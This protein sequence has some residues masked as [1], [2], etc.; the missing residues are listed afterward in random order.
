MVHF[1]VLSLETGTGSL[2]SKGCFEG[3]SIKPSVP[4]INLPSLLHPNEFAESWVPRCMVKCVD[5][6]NTPK[7]PKIKL[8]KIE[9]GVWGIFVAVN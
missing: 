6:Q 2:K 9:L 3:P 7:Y 1:P 5:P 4:Q 8:P